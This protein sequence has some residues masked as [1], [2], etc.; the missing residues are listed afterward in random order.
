LEI[1]AEQE[2]VAEVAGS[3]GSVDLLGVHEAAVQL[4]RPGL[5]TDRAGADEL[6][7]VEVVGRRIGV[8]CADPVQG[9]FR[10]WEPL[11]RSF[12]FLL[13]LPETP[14]RR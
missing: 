4:E 1:V 5:R 13:D 12:R 11:Y 8:R 9:R 14:R 6:E 7:E 2:D 10:D 3:F